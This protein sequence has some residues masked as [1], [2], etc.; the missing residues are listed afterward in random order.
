VGAARGRI[1]A[2]LALD[3]DRRRIVVADTGAASLTRF[4]RLSRVAAPRAGLAALRCRLI[5]GRR[6]QIRVHLASRGWP[7]VG[8]PQYGEPRWQQILD[9][10]LAARLR[11]FPRQALHAWTLRVRHPATGE[12]VSIESPVPADMQELMTAVGLTAL[13]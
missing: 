12:P 8:D 3:R 5:T 9:P 4:E 2:P 1:D 11:A 6:H 10:D 7:I 13:V